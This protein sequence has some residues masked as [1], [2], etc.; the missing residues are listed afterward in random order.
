MF[1]STIQIYP[2]VVMFLNPVRV[3]VRLM[4]QN[5]LFPHLMIIVLSTETCHPLHRIFFPSTAKQRA[6]LVEW[7]N[8]ILPDLSLP[9]NASDKELQG[10]LVDGTVLCRILNKLK[11]GSVTEVV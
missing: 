6:T 3:M 9:I 11:P 5:V 8:S 1:D 7:L 2:V 10:F 4:V